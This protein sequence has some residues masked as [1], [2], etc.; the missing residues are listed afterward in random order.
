[1]YNTNYLY[2]VQNENDN[3]KYLIIYVCKR[4]PNLNGRWLCL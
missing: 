3:L 4:K 1:M 2:L